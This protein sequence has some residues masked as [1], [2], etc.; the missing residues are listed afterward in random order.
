MSSSSKMRSAAS[1]TST[2]TPRVVP[3]RPRGSAF[4]EPPAGGPGTRPDLFSS[5]VYTFTRFLG[6][7]PLLS[8]GGE[9][10]HGG[11]APPHTDLSVWRGPAGFYNGPREAGKRPRE[12]REGRECGKQAYSRILPTTAYVFSLLSFDDELIAVSLAPLARN[13][14]VQGAGQKYPVRSQSRGQCILG[15]SRRLRMSF[16]CS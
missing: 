12:V 10:T 2:P 16:S 1:T 5:Y 14:C 9:G 7:F 8:P 11:S 13:M 15:F 6:Y 3:R 4:L